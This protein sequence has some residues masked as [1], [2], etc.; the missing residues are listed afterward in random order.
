MQTFDLEE[1]GLRALNQTLHDQANDTNQT[2][3]EIINPRGSHAYCR[4][5]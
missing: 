4:R 2:S 1:Q 3:W 5:P